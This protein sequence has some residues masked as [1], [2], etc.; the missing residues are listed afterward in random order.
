MFSWT[1]SRALMT[2]RKPRF[3]ALLA[4]ASFPFLYSSQL[5]TMR[6]EEIGSRETED[7]ETVVECYEDNRFFLID[8][9]ISGSRSRY[10]P[11]V[12]TLSTP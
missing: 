7:S 6:R 5:R 9:I 8:H 4:A 2:S 10:I 3:A 11:S 12:F 1:Q